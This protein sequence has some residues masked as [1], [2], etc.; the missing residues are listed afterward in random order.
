MSE[1]SQ[2]ALS[3]GSVTTGCR[4][5]GGPLVFLWVSEQGSKAGDTPNNASCLPN[6]ISGFERIYCVRAGEEVMDDR[7]GLQVMGDDL[8]SPH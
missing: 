1:Q 3:R 8:P 6:S 4:L 7:F 2:G 5:S